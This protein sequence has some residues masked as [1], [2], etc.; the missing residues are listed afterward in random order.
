MHGVSLIK[1][2]V[3]YTYVHPTRKETSINA[4][5]V[6]FYQRVEPVRGVCATLDNKQSANMTLKRKS[7]HMQL[8]GWRIR[9]RLPAADVNPAPFET[10]S[11]HVFTS[12]H[13]HTSEIQQHP[14]K[15]LHEAM[16][17]LEEVTS[18]EVHFD[19][20]HCVFETKR[21]QPRDWH[22]LKSFVR[23]LRWVFCKGGLN[24][25][26][27]TSADITR[28]VDNVGWC[29]DDQDRQWKTRNEHGLVL[30]DVLIDIELI[31]LD[32]EYVDTIDI[33]GAPVTWANEAK[34]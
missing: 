10:V 1:T 25:K 14:R 6:Y 17:V 18:E 9:I 34:V 19:L 29:R 22:T 2:G 3:W 23:E 16:Q 27:N 33:V 28:R 21:E 15:Q 12:K 4:H 11:M 26:S 20:K 13:R 32:S 31:R 24:D 7:S 8:T 5:I 30:D